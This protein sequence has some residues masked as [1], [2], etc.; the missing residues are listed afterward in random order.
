MKLKQVCICILVLIWY[1]S[2]KV[3]IY[4]YISSIFTRLR[5]E[6]GDKLLKNIQIKIILMVI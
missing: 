6:A 5:P 4:T 1:L 2:R 3:N